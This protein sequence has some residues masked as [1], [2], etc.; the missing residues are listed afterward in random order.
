VLS[1]NAVK[2]DIRGRLQISYDPDRYFWKQAYDMSRQAWVPDHEHG[3][4]RPGVVYEWVPDPSDSEKGRWTSSDYAQWKADQVALEKNRVGALAAEFR[5]KVARELVDAVDR[6]LVD[7]A[8]K[9]KIEAALEKLLAADLKAP[10]DPALRTALG[11]AVQECIDALPPAVDALSKGRL[12][13]L[14]RSIEVTWLEALIRNVRANAPKPPLVRI[15]MERRY[16]VPVRRGGYFVPVTGSLAWPP[17]GAPPEP[18]TS[19]A[20]R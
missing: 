3:D 15:L 2:R 12:T 9:V 13:D 8:G 4:W 7:Q 20:G 16:R 11:E 6:G 14:K 17:C 10:L 19:C 1:L 5:D 18:C